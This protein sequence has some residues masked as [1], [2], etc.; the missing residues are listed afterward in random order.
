MCFFLRFLFSIRPGKTGPRVLDWGLGWP[1]QFQWWP[2]ILQRRRVADFKHHKTWMMGICTG[3]SDI[4]G[5]KTCKNISKPW[6]L[7]DVPSLWQK[8]I[9]VLLGECLPISQGLWLNGLMKSW[10]R[11]NRKQTPFHI[12]SQLYLCNIKKHVVC[13]VHLHLKAKLH[14]FTATRSR[15]AKKLAPNFAVSVSPEI[16]EFVCSCQLCSSCPFILG[17][18]SIFANDSNHLSMTVFSRGFVQAD[19]HSACRPGDFDMRE[20][21]RADEKEMHAGCDL[22]TFRSIW[23]RATYGTMETMVMGQM[24]I[25]SHVGWLSITSLGPWSQRMVSVEART[26]APHRNVRQQSIV[27]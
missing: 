1:S 21:L 19:F 23:E 13:A 15:R 6:F 4:L 16:I 18:R 10:R 22:M 7:E 2:W 3:K 26:T 8:I 14:M 25:P 9:A 11:N 17:W 27:Q 24:T 12:F 20:P 5:I